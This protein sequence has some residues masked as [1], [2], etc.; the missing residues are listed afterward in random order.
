VSEPRAFDVDM[1][2]GKLKEHKS[3]GIDYILA[4]LIKA[5]GRTIAYGIH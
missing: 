3:P 5:G 1:A 2:I 4:E